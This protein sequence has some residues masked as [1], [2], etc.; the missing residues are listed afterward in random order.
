[1]NNKTIVVALSGASGSIYG[2]RLVKAL[3]DLKINVFVILSN[4]A[5]KEFDRLVGL[6]TSQSGVGVVVLA[7]NT[8]DFRASQISENL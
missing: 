6:E 5:K 7:R 8:D 2:I 3:I 1:M 4:A